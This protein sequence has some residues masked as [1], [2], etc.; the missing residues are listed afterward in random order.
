M[1]TRWLVENAGPV[2]NA[3]ALRIACCKINPAD[4]RKRNRRRTHRARLQ[5]DVEVAPYQPLLAKSLARLADHNDFGVRRRIVPFPR[6]VASLCQ[7]RARWSNKHGADRHFT[8]CC[9]GS[10]FAKRQVHVA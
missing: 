6:P 1:M 2:L 4:T 8:A 3:A 5:R 10:S 9:G 7:N